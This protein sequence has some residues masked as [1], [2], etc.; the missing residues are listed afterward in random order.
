MLAR[1]SRIRG[2]PG[3]HPKAKPNKGACRLLRAC[4]GARAQD[5][6]WCW[7]NG[8]RSSLAMEIPSGLPH[9]I[10]AA[11]GAPPELGRQSRETL[12]CP[13]ARGSG[14]RLPVCVLQDGDAGLEINGLRACLHLEAAHRAH[15]KLVVHVTNYMCYRHHGREARA[16]LCTRVRRSHGLESSPPASAFAVSDPPFPRGHHS[17]P[18][19]SVVCNDGFSSNVQYKLRNDS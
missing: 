1:T 13:A 2:C 4:S 9:F 3:S 10:S 5:W 11:V 12:G 16:A 8:F 6:W 14:N 19:R 18:Q 7:K 17:P 15:Y